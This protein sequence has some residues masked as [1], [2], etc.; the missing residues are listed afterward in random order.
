MDQEDK[1]GDCECGDKTINGGCLGIDCPFENNINNSVIVDESNSFTD[2]RCSYTN[3]DSNP[4]INFSSSGNPNSTNLSNSD[5]GRG[6]TYSYCSPIINFSSNSN[7][8]IR[9]SRICKICKVIKN[10]NCFDLKKV[11][12]SECN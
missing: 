5:P 1:L 12:C 6:Y 9:T 3:S 8:Y 7:S 11:L 2:L 10:T 4:I